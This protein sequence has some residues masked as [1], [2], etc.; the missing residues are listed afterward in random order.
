MYDTYKPSGKI[1]PIFVLW[2]FL[3]ILLTIGAAFL[4]ELGLYWIPIIYL[5]ILLTLVMGFVI[6]ML[7]GIVIKQGKIRNTLI[8]FLCMSSL[9]VVGIG[10]KF[11]FQYLR[12]RGEVKRALAN[13]TLQN[14]KAE[15]GREVAAEDF[16]KFR[17]GALQRYT[18]LVHLQERVE[19]GWQIGKAGR[20]NQGNPV[21]GI[22]VY[23][24]WLIEAGAIFFVAFSAMLGAMRV[25]FSEKLG[26]WADEN[27]VVMS[28]P[29]TNEEM[30]GKIKSANSVQDLLELPVPK[31]DESNQLAV[32]TV[33]SVPGV[34]MEDA[35]L[36]VELQTHLINGKGE[37]E[38]KTKSLVA[39]A[40]LTTAQR[41]Q[42]KENAETMSEAFA[43]YRASLMNK[44]AST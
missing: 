22:M 9:M 30:V 15:V 8:A 17:D 33:H 38:V 5:N 35:Y 11:S 42:L 27:E 26:L 25:P 6:G 4:Y 29:I 23:I 39:N 41:S 14:L 16:D 18:P 1:S 19:R 43:D 40:I 10:G 12:A 21:S 32:Y 31:S 34:E 28:L 3:A 2:L 13:L 20:A 44:E 7:T 24:V 36:S 37:K